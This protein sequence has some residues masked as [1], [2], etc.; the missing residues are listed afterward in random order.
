MQKC[1]MHLFKTHLSQLIDWGLLKLFLGGELTLILLYIMLGL[2]KI[3]TS[4]LSHL[5]GPIWIVEYLQIVHGLFMLVIFIIWCV[6]H[7]VQY[8]K[9][10]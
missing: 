5:L 9:N 3:V 4:N 1:A 8:Y 7:V 10:F 2:T 6:E